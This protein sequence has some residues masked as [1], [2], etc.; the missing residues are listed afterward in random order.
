VALNA[1]IVTTKQTIDAENFWDFAVP[2][3]T[4]LAAGE[5]VKEIQIPTPPPASRAPSSSSPCA[6]PSTSPSSTAPP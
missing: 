3:S 1:K 5:I 2:G 4:V 6:H